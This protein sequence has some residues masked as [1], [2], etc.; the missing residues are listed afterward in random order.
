MTYASA[1]PKNDRSVYDAVRY[2][3]HD[4]DDDDNE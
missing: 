3:Y 4:D 1:G 2:A